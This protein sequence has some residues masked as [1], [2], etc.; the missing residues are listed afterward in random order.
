MNGEIIKGRKRTNP[1]YL[2]IENIPQ[3][4]TGPESPPPPQTPSESGSSPQTPTGPESPPPPQIPSEPESSPQTP[5]GPESPPPPQT[6]SEPE[7]SP[8][9]PPQTPTEPE[10]P[11]TEY[12]DTMQLR[13]PLLVYNTFEKSQPT[14]TTQTIEINTEE[15]IID[16]CITLDDIASEKV[17]QLIN[18][19][20]NDPDL[21]DIFRDIEEQM[22]FEELGMDIDLPEQN[23]LE[24]ELFGW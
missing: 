7:S 6:P 3:T 13:I 17:D 12:N 21:K 5:T 24:D 1:Q 19:L 18:E 10:S 16:P 8:Q 11:P 9:T 15:E 14:V 20:R 2:D 4:P 22:E 23:L